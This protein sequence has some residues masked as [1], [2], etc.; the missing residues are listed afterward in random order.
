[1]GKV[2]KARRVREAKRREPFLFAESTFIAPT[3]SRRLPSDAILLFM[4]V[5]AE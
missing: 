1:M 5:F 3:G 2:E 4:T